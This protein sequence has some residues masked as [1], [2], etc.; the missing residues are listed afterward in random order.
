MAKVKQFKGYGNYKG[1]LS[2]IDVAR[3]EWAEAKDKKDYNGK[4]VYKSGAIAK[5]QLRLKTNHDNMIFLDLMEFLS[6]VGKD[7][8]LFNTEKGNKN[9]KKVK[10]A[11]RYKYK[12]SDED[13]KNGKHGFE[14]IGVR[15]RSGEEE[16]VNL[17]PLD[18]IEYILA[19]FKEGDSV[20]V[21]T[22]RSHSQK[23]DKKYKSNE[24]NR[25]FS[26]TEPVD[27]DAEDFEEVSDF[28][29]TLVFDEIIE[30]EDNEHLVTGKWLD[31]RGE[32][33]DVDFVTLDED[34]VAYLKELSYGAQLTVEG[35]AHNRVV[36]AEK[37]SDDE[38]EQGSNVIGKR[39][40]SYQNNSATRE[41]VSEKKYDEICAITDV[42]EGAYEEEPSELNEEVPPW[43][44]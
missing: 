18:A 35:V 3:K 6:K 10:Y 23:G 19:K 11:D 40:K 27:F 37:Q 24:I 31:W 42:L 13:K 8:I 26:T 7:V 29:D 12:V 16:S 43:M 15:A 21:G 30:L 38:P 1:I 14:V 4:S 2:G 22:Q 33:V 32:F 17:L 36:Y 34:I 39:P 41:I 20:F 25:I 28:Q 5:I 44:Q 9:Q